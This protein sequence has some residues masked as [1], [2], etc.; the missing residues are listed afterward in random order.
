[1][2][3]DSATRRHVLAAT[4]LAIGAGALAGCTSGNSG[5]G[6]GNGGNGN[7]GA[8]EFDGW[9]DGVSNYDGVD[10]ETGSG[11]VAVEV[12]AGSDGLLF[13]PPAVRVDAGTTVVWEWTGAGGAHNVVDEGGAFESELK[14]DAG[15]TFEYTFEEA[16]TYTYYCNPHQAQGMKGVVVVE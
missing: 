5:N 7:G 9:F 3:R 16:G 13:A 14:G 11:E 10:D 12:G 8:E 2:P 6:G 4:G 15:A 1:M